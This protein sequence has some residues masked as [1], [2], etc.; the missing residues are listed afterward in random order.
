MSAFRGRLRSHHVASHRKARLAFRPLKRQPRTTQIKKFQAVAGLNGTGDEA[1]VLNA[2]AW[3]ALIAT[4]AAAPLGGSKQLTLAVQDSLTSNGFST[5]LTGVYDSATAKQLAGFVRQRSGPSRRQWQ[6]GLVD[7]DTWHLLA[8]GCN[9]SNSPAG[10]P[11]ETRCLSMSFH[12]FSPAFTAFHCG[13]TAGGAFWFDAGWPQ[14]NMTVPMLSCL[15]GAGFE[16]ATFECWVE[17]SHAA[18][19]APQPPHHSGSFWPGC[20]ANIANARAAGFAAGKA[21]CLSLSFHWLSP[22]FTAVLLH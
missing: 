2:Q 8:S 10:Q 22:P 13:S 4:A 14:G 11:G 1:G 16:F 7:A 21:H 17:Q 6:D 3:P 15:R 19:G 20:T 12:R 9:S 5:P 18:P